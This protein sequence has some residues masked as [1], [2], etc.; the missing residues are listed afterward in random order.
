LA[1]F[2]Y[3]DQ[4]YWTARLWH[5]GKTH[6]SFLLKLPLKT[7]IPNSEQ[8]AQ[9]KNWRD[10]MSPNR[11][12]LVLLCL[13]ILVNLVG[14][15]DDDDPA[16][17]VVPD[18]PS[19]VSVVISP[20]SAT[21]TNIGEDLQFNAMAFDAQGAAVDT[22]FIWASSNSSVVE[23]SPNGTALATG[24]GSAEIF[25]TAGV[26]TDTASVIVDVIGAIQREWISGQDGDW[27]NPANWSGGIVPQADDLAIITA[28]GTYSVTM[29]DDVEIRG[30]LLGNDIGTQT[31][32]TNSFQMSFDYG[33][34]SEGAELNL[35]GGVNVMVGAVWSGGAVTGA[36]TMTVTRGAELNL[37]GNPLELSAALVNLGRITVL[38]DASLRVRGGMLDNT[39]GGLF[40]LQGDA[41]VS[42]M[43][44]GVFYNA[45][46]IEKSEGQ[47]EAAIFT[48][49]SDFTTNGIMRVESGNLWVSGGTL[50]NVVEI[51][52]GA[53]LR[54]TGSTTIPSI[55]SRGE[56]F[57]EINGSVNFGTDEGQSMAL[58]NLILDSGGDPS[59]SGPAFLRI[60][61][62]FIW[63]KGVI[64]DLGEFITQSGSITRF[65]T[66]ATKG[67]SNLNW[68][69]LGQVQANQ[70]LDL[71]FH[72]DATIMLRP[73]GRWTQSNGGTLSLG[74]GGAGGLHVR[75][76]FEKN[77][78][79]AFVVQTPFYCDGM[80]NLAEGA[81]TV[82]GDFHLLETGVITGGGTDEV[83]N[84]TRL[85]VVD[86]PSATMAGTI[87][88]DLDGA[89]ARMA[90][91]GNVELE[92]TFR[93]ELDVSLNGD[94]STES[95][96]FLRGGQELNGTMVLNVVNFP[97]AGEDYRLVTMIDGI[98]SFEI[99]GGEVFNHILQGPLGIMARY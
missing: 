75:G 46:T 39:A 45:G 50:Q 87:R 35:T 10:E 69:V 20:G 23:I 32:D 94:I 63:R 70:E 91:N 79:G 53:I 48:S 68:N 85:I 9:P 22:S 90:I 27:Q 15:S 33:G 29:T 30:L 4:K 37:V 14:C 1:A 96:N 36:G 55:I 62:S 78:P 31:L 7:Q 40:E 3:S 13:A 99:T 8:N 38:P 92:S 17:P 66:T 24:V 88:P 73:A 2:S 43:S 54:Q 84:N 98:G 89:P 49:S 60:D 11:H 74:L 57:F 16:S 83:L 93:L 44:S 52:E 65:E 97:N 47:Q 82:Q 71:S 6:L 51:A 28:P 21:F 34:L 86:S 76:E 64:G 41:V 5:N 77:G 25:S 58:L 42:V 95:L 18:D 19:I 26:V 80:M 12:W 72:N 67:I 61:E 59:I 81:L 56:G